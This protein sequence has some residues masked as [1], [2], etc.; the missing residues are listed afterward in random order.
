MDTERADSPLLTVRGLV[1]RIR[2]ES[3]QARSPVGERGIRRAIARGELPAA[4]VGNA[5]LIRWSDWREFVQRLAAARRPTPLPPT[6]LGLVERDVLAHVRR[7]R[8]RA[9]GR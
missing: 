8:K 6:A 3:G 5:D 9:V 1:A 2:D 7:E 4:R